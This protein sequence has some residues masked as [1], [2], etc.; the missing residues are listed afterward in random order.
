MAAARGFAHTNGLSLHSWIA[1]ETGAHESMPVPYFN[2]L[3]GGAHASNKLAFQEFMIA[4]AGAASIEDAI[5]CCAEIYHHLS[6]GIHRA[7]SDTGFGEE[8]GFAPAISRP[9]AALDLLMEAIHGAGY[10]AGVD[11]V[12]I[13]MDAAANGF[14]DTET[15]Q[16]EGVSMTHDEVIDYYDHLINTYPITSIEDGLAETDR[17]G[18][19]KLR[20][21]LGD[22]IQIVGDDLFVTD[23]SR[24]ARGADESLANATVIKPNQAGTVSRTLAAIRTARGHRMNTMI[25]HRSGE[26]LDTFI[27]DL[28]GGSGAGRMKAGAPARGERIAKY[29]RL[30]EIEVANPTLP[31]AVTTY[32][33]ADVHSPETGAHP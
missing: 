3:N 32:D 24:I 6:I 14:F 13:A 16:L 12:S 29:N 17:R 8:G 15:Y 33:G 26:T 5:Q 4:P 27:A 1:R 23:A 30:I 18:W 7:Y 19:A 9:E 28:A 11:S 2:V 25:A 10:K 22:S 31:Y 21:R 20:D